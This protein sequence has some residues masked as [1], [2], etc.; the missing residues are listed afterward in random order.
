MAA[1]P[2]LHVVVKLQGTED[3]LCFLKAATLATQVIKDCKVTAKCQ[4][5]RLQDASGMTIVEDSTALPAGTYFFT[6]AESIGMSILSNMS[7][8]ALL[9]LVNNLASSITA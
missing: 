3:L 6:P 4:E 1:N 2:L 7:C 9:G 5:G 8:T